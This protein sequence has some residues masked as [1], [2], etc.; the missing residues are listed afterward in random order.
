M[1]KIRVELFGSVSLLLC[2]WFANRAVFRGISGMC[3]GDDSPIGTS[4]MKN[5]DPPIEPNGFVASAHSPAN[6]LRPR[7]SG[8]SLAL[9]ALSGMALVWAT[10]TI[11]QS[12]SSFRLVGLWP[13]YL[14]G[15]VTCVATAGRYA[16]L[17]TTLAAGL[18]GCNSRG[19]RGRLEVMDVSDP[20]RPR[21]VGGHDFHDPSSGFKRRATMCMLPQA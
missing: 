10:G 14:R 18:G 13:G 8:K 4:L 11:G 3:D 1:K 6:S 2:R 15:D 21:W 9:L 16:Y 7:A 20:A 5:N 19:W 12:P 17:G